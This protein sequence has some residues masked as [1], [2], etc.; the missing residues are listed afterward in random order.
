LQSLTPELKVLY[1]SGYSLDLVRGDF[2]LKTGLN[3]IPK[4]YTATALAKAVR[5]CLD[6]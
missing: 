5:E 6:R 2:S 3:F 1:T 4:P